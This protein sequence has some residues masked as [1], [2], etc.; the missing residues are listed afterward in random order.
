MELQDLKKLKSFHFYNQKA[1][2]HDVTKTPED[3]QATQKLNN[4]INDL[5]QIKNHEDTQ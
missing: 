5:K 2:A 4:N 3:V 1:I